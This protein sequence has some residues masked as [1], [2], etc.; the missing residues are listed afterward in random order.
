M[1]VKCQR[2]EITGAEQ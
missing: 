2:L 1:Q